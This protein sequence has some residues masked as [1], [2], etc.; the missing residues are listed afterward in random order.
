[1]SIQDQCGPLSASLWQTSLVVHIPLGPIRYMPAEAGRHAH[2]AL[3]SGGKIW[4][5]GDG[6]KLHL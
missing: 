4:G 6:V 1:M 2:K 3:H 5:P